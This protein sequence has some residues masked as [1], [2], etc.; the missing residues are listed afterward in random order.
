M[1]VPKHAGTTD[2]VEN[3]R[4]PHQKV[5]ACELLLNY[6]AERIMVSVFDNN[7]ETGVAI[8]DPGF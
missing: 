3:H 7:E 5:G 6:C 2:C 4:L 8:D 1:E